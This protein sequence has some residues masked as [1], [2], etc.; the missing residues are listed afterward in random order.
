MI[1]RFK[2]CLYVD[3]PCL[4]TLLAREQWLRESKD[5]QH[6]GEVAPDVVCAVIDKD[7][8][9][10]GE[11]KDGYEPLDGCTRYYPGWKYYPVDLIVGLYNRLHYRGLTDGFGEYERPPLVSQTWGPQRMPL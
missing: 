3:K 4:D 9:P 2:Y 1:P 7:C 6:A 8:A 10:E 5:R 11:G